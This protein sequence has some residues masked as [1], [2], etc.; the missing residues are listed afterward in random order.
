MS[1]S[2]AYNDIEQH[3]RHHRDLLVSRYTRAAG[4]HHAAEDIVQNTYVKMLENSEGIRDVGAVLQTRL[5]QQFAEYKRKEQAG[6]LV[7]ESN[8]DKYEDPYNLEKMVIHRDLLEKIA[9]QMNLKKESHRDILRMAFLHHM[10]PREIADCMPQSVDNIKQI[11]SR[12]RV[13]AKE[14]FT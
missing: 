6:G 12:F 13:E 3:Y 5:N 2:K 1:Q 8:I 11:M 7:Y 4:S 9:D 14:M 10:M